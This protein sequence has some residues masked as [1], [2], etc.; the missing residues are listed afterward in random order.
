VAA[1]RVGLTGGIGS[2]KSTVAEMW[3]ERG[4]MIIDAD[5]L[6]R[7]VV[8]PGSDGLRAIGE[9]WPGVIAADGSLDRPALAAIVFHDDAEREALQDIIHPRV[10]ALGNAREAEAPDGT[11]AVH[12]IPL[13]FEG[14]YWQ[15]C[16]ATVVVVAPD[17]ARVTRVVE[18]DGVNAE[19]VL[20]RMRAQIAPERARELA[21]VT[22]E[23]N[24]DIAAL[25]IRADA[26]YDDLSSRAQS[27]DNHRA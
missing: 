7:E 16:A 17:P 18:R 6:A 3:R 21:T 24:G 19:G 12:V 15:T 20:A 23:N 26:V 9:R 11:V 27:R 4:A 13:L 22:I 14:D 25:R 10:R 2:G 8:A 1:L 5:V